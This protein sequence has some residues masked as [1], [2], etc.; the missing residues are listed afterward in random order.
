MNVKKLSSILL[1][2][3]F[4]IA[5]WLNSEITSEITIPKVS[6][7]DVTFYEVNPCKV[8][9]IRFVINNTESIYQ[10]HFYFRPDNRSPI[11][12]FGRIS[13]VTVLQKGLETQFFISIG[14][15][16]V[17]NLLLQGL[18]WISCLSLIPKNS[19][20]NEKDLKIKFHNLSILIISYYFTY[21]IYAESRYY[22]NIL[23][24]FDLRNIKTYVLIFILYY[25]IAIN[26]IEVFEERSANFINYLPYVFLVSG[27]FS[28]FNFNF[29]STIFL[30]LGVRSFLLGETN[31][32]FNFSYATLAVWW[33][34]NSRG[35][36]YFNVG[37]IR[38]FT[39]SIFEFNANLSWIIFAYLL[40]LGLRKIYHLN[41]DNF[42]LRIFTKNLSVTS[43]LLVVLGV[44][45]SNLPLIN[46]LN[47]YYLGLQRW[48]VESTN[49]FAY[50][51]FVNYEGV[52]IDIVRISW[53][54]LYPSSET[55]G[56]FYGLCLMFILFYIT[57]KKRI[58][59]YDYLGILS[60][61]TGLYFSD[62]Q[63]SIILIFCSTLLYLFV[64]NF[65]LPKIKPV[66]LILLFATGIASAIYVFAFGNFSEAYTF[67]SESLTSQG[68]PYHS[69]EYVSSYTE[70]IDSNYERKSLFSYF[71]GAFSFIAYLL[72]RSQMWGIFF[73]RYNPSHSE[74]MLGSGPFNLG[75]LYGEVNIN[76]TEGLLLPHSSLLSYIVYLGII[77]VSI[78]FSILVYKLVI[79]RRNIEFNLVS[80]Y[81]FINIIKNDSLNYFAPFVIYSVLLMLLNKKERLPFFKDSF[82]ENQVGSTNK[83]NH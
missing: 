76:N 60:A 80:I 25:F 30:Y 53:R 68:K 74:L 28:G 10:N 75:Q 67:M 70:F 18:F 69:S 47:Y 8:S 77:P 58:G 51:E 5:P 21:S 42:S 16:S 83:I 82:F 41:K 79:N 17:L 72:N 63:T 34:F 32:F 31:R 61:S 35:S 22:E 12:C 13:G 59:F 48:G 37:K 49:P 20:K 14:T 73:A 50:E 38:G 33:L 81:I 54:G 64:L 45:S 43:F 11:E 56:E 9:L 15:S 27:L 52:T 26:L 24:K 55:I 19:T 23:Y 29:F 2:I 4:L 57:K 66:I 46:F 6:Q 7:E 65:N 78:L 3:I 39:S 44:I 1:V 40:M 71:F 36:F 62:N